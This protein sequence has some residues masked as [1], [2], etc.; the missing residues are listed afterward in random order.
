M[1]VSKIVSQVESVFAQNKKNL[2]RVLGRGIISTSQPFRQLHQ[3][4]PSSLDRR[5]KTAKS[6]RTQG[7]VTHFRENHHGL[8]LGN[9]NF[10]TLTGKD[11]ELVDEAKYHLDIV[12]V[13]S[14]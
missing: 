13:S 1:M 7:Y 5:S 8:L 14:T 6:N 9:W 11:L 10:F 3:R 2:D 12:G 4:A